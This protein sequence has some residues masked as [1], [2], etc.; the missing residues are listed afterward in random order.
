MEKHCGKCS[1]LGEPNFEC[2]FEYKNIF[3]EDEYGKYN[4]IVGKEVL[5]G[6]QLYTIL[7][8]MMPSNLKDAALDHIIKRRKLII[9]KYE[10]VS[11]NDMLEYLG[12]LTDEEL[13]AY[14]NKINEIKLKYL[15]AL[16]M[17]KIQSDSLKS[18][19][20]FQNEHDMIVK[21]RVRKI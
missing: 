20:S 11:V 17:Y 21:K 6:T 5:T 8:S 7:P 16:Q 15:Q 12:N 19:E 9:E 1:V 2:Y 14:L 4:V 3:R 13:T 18:N 10:E